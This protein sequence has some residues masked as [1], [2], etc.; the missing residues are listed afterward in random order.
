MRKEIRILAAAIAI[1]AGTA[2][3]RTASPQ[4]DAEI[5]TLRC[6]GRVREFIVHAPS[7]LPDNAPLVFVL[8]GAWNNG[9]NFRRETGFDRI[10]DEDKF[11]V[12]YPYA[13]D[14]RLGKDWDVSG[15]DDVDFL[16][17]LVGEMKDRF[18]I[19][20]TRIYATG[21]SMGG[22]MCHH[23]ACR[24]SNV[25]AAV[26]PVAGHCRNLQN[27]P[28]P[29]TCSRPVPILMIH[30]TADPVV[31]YDLLADDVK[32]WIERNGGCPGKAAVTEPYPAS[33][34]ESNVKREVYGPC[35]GGAEVAVMSVKGLAHNYPGGNGA[36]NAS[37]HA[38]REAWAFLRRFS[39]N[40]VI[41]QTAK[42]LKKAAAA[43]RRRV[44]LKDGWY[45]IDGRKFFVN[46]LGYEI[47]A[48]PGQHPKQNRRPEPARVRRDLSVIKRAGFN[49]IR[50]W[51]ELFESELRVVQRSGLKAVLGIW[52]KPDVDFSDRKIVAEELGHVQKVLSYSRNYDC[53]I[54]YLIMNEPMPQHIRKAGA[55]AAV[56]LWKKVIETIHREHPGIPV[57]ISGNAAITDFVDMNVFDVYAYN[58]YDYDGDNSTIGYT[59]TLRLL[60][61]RNGGGKPL[62]LTEFGLSVSRQGW[63]RYGSNTLAQQAAAIPKYYRDLLDAGASGACAFYYAD[64][65]WKGGEPSVHNDTPEEWFGYWGYGGLGDTVGTPRP[66][67][68]AVTQY[69]TALVCSPKNQA[70]YRNEIPLEIFLRDN[71]TRM[72]I[73]YQDRI[74]FSADSIVSNHLRNRISFEGENLTDR[75]L[76][77]EFFGRDGSLLKQESLIVLT[78]GSEITW[79]T[80]TLETGM[81]NLDEGK[82]VRV[83]VRVQNGDIFTLGDRVRTIFAPHIGWNP[84][85]KRQR[86]IDPAGKDQAFQDSFSIPD[87]SPL[88]GLAAGVD[89]RYGKFTRTICDQKIIYRGDWADP[90][91]IK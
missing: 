20:S 13:V 76:V 12:V 87:E 84:G 15:T 53:I 44:E 43:R 72:R 8:H 24:A 31:R 40:G 5:E 3:G 75:E 29:C 73:L 38:A 46:A 86:D 51:D 88:L 34:P 41:P 23:L 91:R 81:K 17:A 28:Q 89:V 66:V 70:F 11:V 1:F 90:I 30:G 22:Y 78:G 42:G 61:E 79:P 69:N 65:W 49:A 59:N 19:D 63:G 58:L 50:T 83:E 14:R 27:E 52:V 2:G 57:T 77:F 18:R 37:I 35:N 33:D 6:R 10:A 4:S 7:D 48:R 68:H 54:T 67:W 47:G 62:M 9:E 80:I 39:L 16:L 25:F 32:G 71:V 60:K 85:E 45:F 26:A 64:G 56:D 55:Q 36:E 21:F 82:T 74:V